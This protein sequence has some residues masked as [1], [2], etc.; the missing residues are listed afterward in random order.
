[1]GTI[2]LCCDQSGDTYREVTTLLPTLDST[3][4]QSSVISA[5]VRFYISDDD[6]RPRQLYSIACLFDSVEEG[7]TF[8][9]SFPN[10]S[11]PIFNFQSGSVEYQFPLQYIL[12]S[13]RLKHP[14]TVHFYLIHLTQDDEQVVIAESQA[15]TYR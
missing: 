12:G 1:M 11:Y 15:L 9:G 8:D 4:T 14:I 10:D 13:Q 2:C 3:L 6:W 7:T 5:Q